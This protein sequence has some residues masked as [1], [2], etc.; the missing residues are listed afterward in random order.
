MLLLQLWFKLK[1]LLKAGNVAKRIVPELFIVYIQT[2]HGKCAALWSAR[3]RPSHYKF[4]D[5][6]SL[7]AYY[8]MVPINYK[9]LQQ[10]DVL[11][12]IIVLSHYFVLHNCCLSFL[13]LL[14][15]HPWQCPQLPKPPCSDCPLA[16]S[17]CHAFHTQKRRS[18]THE[19]SAPF[20]A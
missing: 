19:G 3:N 9:K 18:H 14:L 15:A 17:F 5:A 6:K 20:L 7:S 13:L 12:S 11:I 8:T 2:S 1:I 16:S 10:T 4:M